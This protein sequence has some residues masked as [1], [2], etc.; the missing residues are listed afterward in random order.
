MQCHIRMH[1]AA[2][3][4]N[5]GGVEKYAYPT[6]KRAL[7]QTLPAECNL[8]LKPSCG[9]LEISTSRKEQSSKL[10][11]ELLAELKCN[12]QQP[13]PIG[14]IKTDSSAKPLRRR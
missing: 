12:Q 13:N 1:M 7:N 10:Q 5:I 8:V 4:F 11:I 6:W 3:W 2:T 14:D 9:S